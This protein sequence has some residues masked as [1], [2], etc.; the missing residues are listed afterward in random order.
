MEVDNGTV[1]LV[2]LDAIGDFIM[3]YS[4]FCE[5]RSFYRNKRMI[6]QPVGSGMEYSG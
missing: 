1:V 6:L 5:Y 2:R 3:S 4:A